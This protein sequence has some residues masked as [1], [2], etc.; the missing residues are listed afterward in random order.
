MNQ[1]VPSNVR[2]SWHLIFVRFIFTCLICKII[3]CSNQ[4][5]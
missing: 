3:V 5:N 1:L 2:I 4:I